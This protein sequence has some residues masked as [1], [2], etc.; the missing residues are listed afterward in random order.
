MFQRRGYVRVGL[1]ENPLQG[2]LASQQERLIEQA[3]MAESDD[4]DEVESSEYSCEM[5]VRHM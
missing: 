1:Q 5:E 4:W 3:L 2:S